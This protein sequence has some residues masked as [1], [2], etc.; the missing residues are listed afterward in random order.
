MSKEVEASLPCFGQGLAIR[1]D[2]RVALKRMALFL[3][4]STWPGTDTC[5]K[6]DLEVK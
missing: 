5:V 1:A 4:S 2:D 3:L 6:P